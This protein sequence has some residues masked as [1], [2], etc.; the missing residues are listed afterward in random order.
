VSEKPNLTIRNL[1]TAD[2]EQTWRAMR[3][4]TDSATTDTQDEI[5]LVEHPPVYTMGLKGRNGTTNEIA[6]IPVIYTDRGG[7]MTYHGPGQIVLYTLLD[8]SR[9]GIGIK[10]LVH[11]MEQAAI[12]FLGEHKIDARRRA[13]APGI[14]VNDAKIGALGLRVRGKRSYHGLSFNVNMDLKPFLR[15]DPCGYEGMEVTQCAD[16][17]LR[18]TP[19]AAGEMLAA[20][21]T[22]LLGYNEAMTSTQIF[23]PSG[24]SATHG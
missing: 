4:F 16:L 20:R 9:L 22:S 19:L 11:T 5:W 15:I 10:T 2:Y 14:Y 7:D 17:G 24:H 18:L 6:G 3:Q 21:L 13:G 12:D 23:T 1:S 8:L